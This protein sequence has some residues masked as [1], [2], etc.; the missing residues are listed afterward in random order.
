[1]GIFGGENFYIDL[2][3]F[4]DNFYRSDRERKQAM[5]EEMPS[6]KMLAE[7]K[8]FFAS[9]VHKLA[10]DFGLSVPGWVFKKKYYLAEPF[11]DCN[12]KGNLRLLFMYNSPS[13]FK[14]RN[15]FVDENVLKRV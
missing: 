2:G 1:M 9:T 10:N 5:L 7:Y 6:D 15:V 12:A 13:E 3:N 14:H 11:F 4:L 8:A